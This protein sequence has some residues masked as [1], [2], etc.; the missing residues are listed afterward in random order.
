MSDTL[1]I[2]FTGTTSISIPPGT[3]KNAVK[4][5]IVREGFTD[6]PGSA[7][8]GFPNLINISLPDS[9]ESIGDAGFTFSNFLKYLYL[10]KGIKNLNPSNPF[11]NGPIEYIDVDPGNPNFC[12]VD[13]VLFSKDMKILYQFPLRKI[14]SSYMIPNT[15]KS[16]YFGAFNRAAYL[17]RIYIPDSVVDLSSQFCYGNG[18]V[19]EEVVIYRYDRQAAPSMGSESFTS[20]TFKKSNIS[21]VYSA[22]AL[23]TCQTCYFSLFSKDIFYIFILM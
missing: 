2:N 4:Y 23:K 13:G 3:N 19:L 5:I 15:V 18:D 10:P 9:L 17:K 7:F 11:D 8:T 14:A 22:K 6:L 12:S 20:T 16:L 1:E 21:Y